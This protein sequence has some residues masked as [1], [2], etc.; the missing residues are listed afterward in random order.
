[1]EQINKHSQTRTTLSWFQQ[2]CKN[3]LITHLSKL[4]GARLIISDADSRHELGDANAELQGV[5][6]IHDSTTYSNIVRGGSIAAAE[7]YIEGL[8]SSPDLTTLIQVFAIAESEV[9]NVEQRSSFMT[10]IQN[11]LLHLSNRNSLNQAKKN[12]MAHYDL[13][14][15]L[16]KRFLDSEMVYSSAIYAHQSQ[17]LEDA[18]QNKFQL[19]C[20]RLEITDGDDI[21]EIGTGWGGLAIYMASHY[22]CH[23]T[24]TT[25]SEQQHAYAEQ[26]I[27]SMG[28]ENKITL[29][30]QDYRTLEGQY[31]KL[32]SIEMIEAVGKEYFDQFFKQCNQLVKP[33]G[34]M[35][36]Q[37][38]TIADQ[39]YDSYSKG[40]DFIQKYIFPGGC[41][42]SITVMTHHLTKHTQMVT[43]SLHDIGLD[44][45]KTL[46]EWRVRFLDKWSELKQLG[47]DDSFKRLW[48]YY[49]CYCEAAF[50]ERKVSTVHLV[51]RK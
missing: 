45:A 24:T 50:L 38:I 40:V 29:L 23:V 11:W 51:A 16:Y 15:E 20:D 28:L 43:E 7:D 49:L 44:Y 4:S 42:P 3:L 5:M 26:R 17:S 2:R 46:K 34:K 21:V 39:R 25:I 30:K 18:Q 33:K 6:E 48:L 41:L 10:K 37:A 12:I 8:W 9:D 1:M 47:Y 35:L 36:I 14:N 22:D 27:K 31:D 32:V 19:I 13:G